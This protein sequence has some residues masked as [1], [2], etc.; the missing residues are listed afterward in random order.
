MCQFQLQS[1]PN[2]DVA[3]GDRGF[4]IQFRFNSDSN[5]VR[6]DF[7]KDL[8]LQDTVA[9]L[10]D[11]GRNRQQ[12]GAKKRRKSSPKIGHFHIKNRTL[13]LSP[14]IVKFMLVCA[15][16]FHTGLNSLIGLDLHDR[17]Y[18]G[19]KKL[20]DDRWMWPDLHCCNRCAVSRNASHWKPKKGSRQWGRL[21]P[22]GFGSHQ[23]WRTHVQPEHGHVALCLGATAFCKSNQRPTML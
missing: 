9:I 10:G 18:T 16:S 8:R 17:T 14:K 19:L 15:E 11:S 21:V 23:P 20:S 12:S 4:P 3:W 22:Q 6:S 2:G 7:Q 5:S 13:L 1:S